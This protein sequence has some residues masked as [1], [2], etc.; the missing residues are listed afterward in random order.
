MKFT[1]EE[2]L[3]SQN[4]SEKSFSLKKVAC[5]GDKTTVNESSIIIN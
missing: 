1:R 4:Y 3:F 2:N 5:K